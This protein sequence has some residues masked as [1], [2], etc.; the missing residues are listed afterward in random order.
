MIA[1]VS[2]AASGFPSLFLIVV[3]LVVVALLI[4]AFW[5]GTR[6]AATRK[7]PGA[8]PSDQSPPSRARQE[9]WRTPDDSGTD[10]DAQGR[11]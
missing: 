10:P 1:S 7:D 11:P 4:G 5:Y 2:L 3:G 8:R 6:R 9:S